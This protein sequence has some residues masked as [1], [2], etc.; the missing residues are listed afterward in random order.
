[1]TSF[2]RQR[3]ELLGF[4]I[5]TKTFAAAAASKM[6]IVGRIRETV[7]WAAAEVLRATDQFVH[8][9]ANQI[10]QILLEEIHLRI[11]FK[12]RSSLRLKQLPYK[13]SIGKPTFRPVSRRAPVRYAFP[14]KISRQILLGGNS[15]SIPEA[16]EAEPAKP[17]ENVI[18]KG[19]AP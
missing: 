10:N 17:R 8:G 19:I 14:L 5:A 15:Q 7:G 18:P 3:F 16:R 11:T 12:T 4:S 1:M 2:K 9:G 6:R 13:T